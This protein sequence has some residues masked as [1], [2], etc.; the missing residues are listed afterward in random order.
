MRFHFLIV[1]SFDCLIFWMGYCVFLR[2]MM[3]MMMGMTVRVFVRVCV[4]DYKYINF[5]IYI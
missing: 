4:C 2:V 5:I 1:R 3:M